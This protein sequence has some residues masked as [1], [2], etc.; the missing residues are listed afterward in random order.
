MNTSSLGNYGELLV[1][2]EASRRGYFVGF[3]PQ[4]C[5]YDLVIDRG[6]GPERIQVKC[7]NIGKDNLFTLNLTGLKNNRTTYTRENVDIIAMVEPVSQK[8]AW[9]PV[10]ECI[11]KVAFFLRVEP[12]K[13]KMSKPCVL[14]D[15]YSEW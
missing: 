14:F 8:I 3:M 15:K 7:R 1:A 6:S 10:E 12:A 4:G 2:S 5:P 11:G 9:V 13:R